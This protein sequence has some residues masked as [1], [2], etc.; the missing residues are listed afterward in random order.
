MLYLITYDLNAPGQRYQE[1]YDTLK[2]W[3]RSACCFLRGFFA[4][5]DGSTPTR[6]RT[7]C[8]HT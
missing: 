4:E 5:L 7:R 8:V 2:S 1:L 6:R 3:G